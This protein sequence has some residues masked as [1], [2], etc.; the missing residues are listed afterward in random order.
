MWDI[1]LH[2]INHPAQLLVKPFYSILIYK[3]DK[4]CE[5]DYI[6][7][8]SLVQFCFSVA[9][10]NDLLNFMTK[11]KTWKKKRVMYNLISIHHS[12][13]ECYYVCYSLLIFHLLFSSP[14][15]FSLILMKLCQLIALVKKTWL[16][17]FQWPW[18]C[19]LRSRSLQSGNFGKAI[20]KTTTSSCKLTLAFVSRLGLGQ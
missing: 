3:N 14:V 7:Y 2:S 8:N 16:A 6:W 13:G 9:F 10:R 5:T 12:Y 4:T 20:L 19:H 1:S 17:Q 11:L 15:K 18:P